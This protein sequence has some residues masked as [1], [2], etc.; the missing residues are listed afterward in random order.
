MLPGL[1]PRR[2][3][4]TGIRSL[5]GSVAGLYQAKGRTEE[6]IKEVATQLARKKFEL[7]SE[8]ILKIEAERK[9]VQADLVSCRCRR[10][11]PCRRCF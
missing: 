4:N 7:D 2:N 11:F 5:A 6:A 1:Q 8:T 10:G 3:K 9:V